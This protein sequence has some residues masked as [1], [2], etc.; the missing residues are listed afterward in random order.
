MDQN[1]HRH[2]VAA[3]ITAAWPEVFP[4]GRLILP[5]F[6]HM[7]LLFL[8]N[9]KIPAIP[10]PGWNFPPMGIMEKWIFLPEET[11]RVVAA[12]P[13]FLA[14][15]KELLDYHA[16]LAPKE[17]LLPHI[18]VSRGPFIREDWEKFPCHI[19]FYIHSIALY[20]SLGFSKYEMLWE[21]KALPPFEEIEHTA[22]IAYIIRGE[23]YHQLALHATLALS[24]SFPQF[25]DYLKKVPEMN[26]IENI[27]QMLNQWIAE[28]DIR[29]GIGL[30]AVSYHATVET[31]ETLEWTMIV[32]V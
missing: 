21:K 25:I 22:D 24:F 17:K 8:G 16:Q 7:T 15:E 2:F 3:E 18:S 20:K 30:K 32:D 9:K 26:S 31:K 27:I 19:P 13:T 28:I 4:A 10:E 11:P 14:G 1:E 5:E 23:N 29:E 6:R 12:V